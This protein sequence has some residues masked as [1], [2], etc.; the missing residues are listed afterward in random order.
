MA[1]LRVNGVEFPEPTAFDVQVEP[2]GRF[3]RNANGNMV[4]DL[5][6]MKIKLGCEWALISDEFFGLIVNLVKPH[7]VVVGFDDPH[8]G[9]AIEKEMFLVPWS[10]SL[11]FEDMGRKWWKGV[12]V[13]FVER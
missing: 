11:A 13:S 4:G 5:I 8:T 12:K 2:I 10:G 6:G 9:Q 3:E 1:L 7:F